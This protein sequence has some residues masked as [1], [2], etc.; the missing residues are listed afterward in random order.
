MR[1]EGFGAAARREEGE[2]PQGSLTDEQRSGSA[3]D[4][5]PEGQ[6]FPI[7]EMG[8]KN[9]FSA[10]SASLRDALG[11]TPLRKFVAE[12][13]EIDSGFENPNGILA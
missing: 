7:Y 9:S 4:P 12:C 1:C 13:V 11:G 8:S 10:P 2:Y 6:A 5:Q 3:K